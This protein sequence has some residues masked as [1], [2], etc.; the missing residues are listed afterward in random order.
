[1]QSFNIEAADPATYGAVNIINVLFILSFV[2][3]VGIAAR[4]RKNWARLVLLAALILAAMS[5][6]ATLSNDG[7]SLTSAIDVISV[8]M[9]AYGMRSSFTGDARGWFTG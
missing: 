7:L 2:F 4:R 9:T 3:L 8:A 6:L 5:M 1:L